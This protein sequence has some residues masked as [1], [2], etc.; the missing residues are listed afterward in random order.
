M[1]V[2]GSLI[3]SGFMTSPLAAFVFMNVG[4]SFFGFVVSGLSCAFL[5]VSPNFSSTIN[6]VANMVGAIAGFVGRS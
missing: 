4:L 1:H 3:I 2:G 5:D 6:T